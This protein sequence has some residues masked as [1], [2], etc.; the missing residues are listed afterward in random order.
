MYSALVLGV[1]GVVTSAVWPPR[2]RR[3]TPWLQ[4]VSRGPSPDDPTL[5]GLTLVDA[6]SPAD[7]E[8]LVR[9]LDRGDGADELAVRLEQLYHTFPPDERVLRRLSLAQQAAARTGGARE[10]CLTLVYVVAT[11]SVLSRLP[12]LPGPAW[13]AAPR[14]RRRHTR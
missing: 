3:L 8:R 13:K 7:V 4:W 10:Y 6:P 11:E 9:L 12:P 5:R 2:T 14:R 1:A